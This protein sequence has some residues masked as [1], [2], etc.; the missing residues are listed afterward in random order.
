MKNIEQL[1]DN[2]R[3][4]SDATKLADP[5]FLNRLYERQKPEYLWIGCSESRSNVD[6]T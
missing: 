3:N 5:E 2:N 4:W 1:L 6:C